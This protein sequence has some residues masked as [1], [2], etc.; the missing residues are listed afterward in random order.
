MKETS[1]MTPSRR[2]VLAGLGAIAAARPA[3]ADSP[4]P[5]AH[6]VLADNPLAMAF[7]DAPARLPGVALV[8]LDG[9]HSTAEFTGRTIL[10][11]LWAEWCQPC[12]GELPDFSKLQKKYANDRFQIMPVLTGTRKKITPEI[13]GKLFG[14][15]HADGLAPLMEE[16]LTSHLMDTL[17]VRGVETELPCNVLIAP[18]GRIVA[19][20]FG[21]KSG[22]PDDART[23]SADGPSLADRAQAGETLSLWGKAAGEQFAQ[24]MAAGFLD[25]A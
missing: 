20:E 13:I 3:N 8:G 5:I 15:L 18:S 17:A 6:G 1:F 25:N 12:L 23:N 19:R 9:S 21:L 4:S 11:P 24:A 7:E 16:G 2:A 22:Q 10:M 14:I